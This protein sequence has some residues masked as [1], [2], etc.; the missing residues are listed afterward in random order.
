MTERTWA[1]LGKVGAGLLSG[2]TIWQGVLALRTPSE[3][4]VNGLAVPYSMLPTV[5][6]DLGVLDDRVNDMLFEYYAGAIVP[7]GDVSPSEWRRLADSIRAG[8]RFRP[9]DVQSLLVATVENQGGS[10][11]TDVVLTVRGGNVARI[12]RAGAPAEVAAI[13]ELLE[14]GDLR[15]AEVVELEVWALHEWSPFGSDEVA[16]TSNEGRGKVKVREPGAFSLVGHLLR[17]VG[18]PLWSLFL[19]ILFLPQVRRAIKNV[20]PSEAESAG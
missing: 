9:P 13:N 5:T 11:A 17:W 19:L 12:S 2:L 1:R 10:S 14:L 6:Q 15:P 20:D 7:D 8:I 16:L 4:V 18:V 3:L